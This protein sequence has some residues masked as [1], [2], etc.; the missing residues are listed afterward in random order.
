[1]HNAQRLCPG[2]H[3]RTR[4]GV[5]AGLH[6]ASA[7][8]RQAPERAARRRCR[9]YG[10]DRR[11]DA[12]RAASITRHGSST[13]SRGRSTCGGQKFIYVPYTGQTN[14]AGLL[15]WNR[16]ADYF[17]QMLKDQFDTLC[18]EGAE[19][20]R[21]MCLSLIRTISG[22]RR[23]QSISM[24]PCVHLCSR[25]RLEHHRPRHRRVLPCPLLRPGVVLDRGA[26]S[27]SAR[28][29]PL[30]SRPHGSQTDGQVT[31]MTGSSCGIG[32][33]TAKA[34]AAEDCRLMLSAHSA[35]QLATA[36][37]V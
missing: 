17:L 4:T 12:R 24:R 33:A 5:L 29:A 16:E 32:L 10:Q 20:G 36:E 11:F 22:A 8:D 27:T 31:L 30:R 26:Q 2:K 37:A 3:R 34:F 1:M 28:M 23:P 18:R 15:A 13:T 6:Y 25:R 21:V 19:N 7:G 9:L 35:V 14:D